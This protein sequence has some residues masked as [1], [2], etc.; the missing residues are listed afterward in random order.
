[1]KIELPIDFENIECITDCWIY[2][3]LIIL[4]TSPYYEDWI[5]S[6]YSLSVN[7]IFNFR[8]GDAERISPEYHDA[9]LQRVPI[10][11]SDLN[12]SNIVDNLKHYLSQ[13]YYVNMF[14]KLFHG[15]VQ[16]KER[17]HEV[18]FYGYDDEKQTFSVIR[19]WG[20][21]FQAVAYDYAYI[22]ETFPG[23]YN[24]FISNEIL[25]M[26]LSLGFQYPVTA[27]KLN[28]Y[29]EPS[30]CVYGAY[31]KLKKELYGG[32][33]CNYDSF[34]LDKYNDKKGYRGIYCLYAFKQMLE[35]EINGERF[36]GQFRGIMAA[37]KKICE[38]RLLIIR[39]MNYILKKWDKVVNEEAKAC[40]NNYIQT[41]ETVQ[42][43]LGLAI[44][45][46]LIHDKSILQR[47]I[48]KIPTVFLKEQQC[49]DGFVNKGVEWNSFN[50]QIL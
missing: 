4:K 2:N 33:Y 12:T 8:F 45:Y 9:I 47:I 46:E 43:W 38:H 44:K 21:S 5:A 36:H 41:F 28:P 20:G 3:R 42:I 32:T 7:N 35:K 37:T 48:S 29:F 13:G 17:Y 30:N 49:L 22:Q 14:I 31:Y 1:M 18:V 40:L 50:R 26:D 24:N 27:F 34:E 16:G 15:I 11:I 19:A 6:H 25:G 10:K 39:S 23:V